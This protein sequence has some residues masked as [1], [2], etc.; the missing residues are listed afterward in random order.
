MQWK[1]TEAVFENLLC[2]E[3]C[4][5]EIVLDHEKSLLPFHRCLQIF[6]GTLFLTKPNKN[7]FVG[8]CRVLGEILLVERSKDNWSYF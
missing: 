3:H 8:K 1:G 2:A 4:S 5:A 6:F 7:I